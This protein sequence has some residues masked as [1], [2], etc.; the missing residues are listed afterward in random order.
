MATR[1]AKPKKGRTPKKPRFKPSTGPHMSKSEP[2]EVKVI[3]CSRCGVRGG[4]LWRVG[5]DLVHM[6]SA[7]CSKAARRADEQ[8]RKEIA[9][10]YIEDHLK[11]SKKEEESDGS[12]ADDNQS[13]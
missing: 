11:E 2:L 7:F 8:K 9:D 4:A 13:T 12:S 1:S 10:K 3:V 6:D 5:D